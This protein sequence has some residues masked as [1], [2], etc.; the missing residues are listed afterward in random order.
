[1]NIKTIFG[2]AVIAGLAASLSGCNDEAYPVIGN[3]LFLAEATSNKTFNQQ[4]SNLTVEDPVTM[5]LTATLAQIADDDVRAALVLDPSLIE[6]YNAKNGT[7]YQMLPDEFLDFE[8]GVEVVIPAGKVVGD[9]VTFT[10]NP[11]TTPNAEVYAVPFRIQKLAGSVDVVGNSDHILY[12]LASPN[13]QHSFIASRSGNGSLSFDIPAIELSEFTVEFWLKVN[14]KAGW[15]TNVGPW[16]GTVKNTNDPSARYREMIFT[17]NSGP[18]TIGELLL[19]WWSDCDIPGQVGPGLQCQ[20]SDTYFDTDPWWEAD[21]WYHIAYTFDGANVVMYKDGV[22]H[23]DKA[24]TKSFNFAHVNL[25]N[26]QGYY[27]EMEMAQLRIWSKCLP[28]ATIADGMSRQI[29][30][31]ADGLYAY[32]PFN[33]G[34]GTV[35]KGSGKIALDIN[36]P[37]ARWSTEV[38]NFAHPND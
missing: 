19:R 31:D 4:V 15:T 34:E 28:Q 10:I 14:N 29:S 1:M 37:N 21:T 38:Y 25:F 13:K 27:Q 32:W 36:A 6:A 20:L 11:Y 16:F 12:L 2:F 8:N 26:F 35:V 23:K 9:A 17:G 7:A 22:K 24:R 33:E 30:A 3:G 5:T 18:I